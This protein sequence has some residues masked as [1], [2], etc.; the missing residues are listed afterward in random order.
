MPLFAWKHTCRIVASGSLPTDP[1]FT[2]QVRDAA[3]SGPDYYGARWYDATLGQFT[4]TGTT[5]AGGRNRYASAGANPETA[6]DPSGYL[7]CCCAAGAVAS[8]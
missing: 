8:G 6:S 5:L 7:Y 3:T 2:V 1:G 4:R